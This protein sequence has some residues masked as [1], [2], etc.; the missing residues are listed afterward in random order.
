MKS[1]SSAAA[2]PTE[3]DMI[4]QE[5]RARGIDPNLFYGQYAAHQNSMAAAPQAKSDKMMAPSNN[6][7]SSANNG[8]N[9]Q[10]HGSN[11]S[12]N[13]NNNSSNSGYARMEI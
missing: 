12:N 9:S 8:N 2:G 11:N 3:W 6:V 7:S 10:F 1:G 4:A 5:L 13:N